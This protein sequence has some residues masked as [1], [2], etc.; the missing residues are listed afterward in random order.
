MDQTDEPSKIDQEEP[1]GQ[2]K[3]LPQTS[4]VFDAPE[5]LLPFYPTYFENSFTQPQQELFRRNGYARLIKNLQIQVIIDLSSCRQL[6]QEFSPYQSLF[7]TWEFRLAFWQGYRHQPYFLTLK[8]GPEVLALL[9]LWY[10]TDK[11]KYFWFGSWW[12]EDNTFFTRDP[13]FI[14]LLLAASPQPLHL[15]AI[16]PEAVNWPK[17]VINFCF[18]DPKY[19]LSTKN[20]RSAEDFLATLKKKRRYNLRR[21]RRIIED[22]SPQI[23]IDHFKDFDTLVTLSKTRFHQKGEDA[24]W[25]DQRRVTTFRQ[26]VELG[27]QKKSYQVRMVTVKIGNRIAAVDLILIYEGCYYPVKCGY[28]VANFPGIGNFVNLLEIDDAIK[29]GMKKLDFLEVNYGWKDKW[30]DSVPLLKYDKPV[31]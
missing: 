15:N 25:D 18:D 24:D 30:F 21:D 27:R 7:D 12:Q 28:D 9:P 16:L 31:T 4:R 20:I 23:I 29:L 2:T 8:N 13:I 6:W 26:V 19:T 11:Q 5:P 10:E 22:Q 3:P 14:P 17:Q 1:P